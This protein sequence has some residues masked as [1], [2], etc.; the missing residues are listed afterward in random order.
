MVVILRLFLA[1]LELGLQALQVYL[2][3]LLLVVERDVEGLLKGFEV[4]DAVGS[5]K[6]V[7]AHSFE[8][9]QLGVGFFL[10]GAFFVG[11][12]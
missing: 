7:K 1:L 11:G 2:S 3:L 12:Q 4:A 6:V 5:A 8:D 9:A 10:L